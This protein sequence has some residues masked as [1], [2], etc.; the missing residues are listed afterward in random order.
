MLPK[1]HPALGAFLRKRPKPPPDWQYIADELSAELQHRMEHTD[2]DGRC[3]CA[4]HLI[5]RVYDAAKLRT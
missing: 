2:E 4:A 1:S 3:P 5:L